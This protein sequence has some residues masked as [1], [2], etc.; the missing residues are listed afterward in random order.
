[1]QQVGP[2]PATVP[3]SPSFRMSRY[4][5]RPQCTHMMMNRVHGQ[6]L[7]CG[8]CGSPSDLGWLYQCEQDDRIPQN[9]SLPDIDATPVIPDSSDYF[10]AKARVAEHLHMSSSVI[11]GIRNGDYDVDQIDRLIAQKEKLISVITEKESLSATAPPNSVRNSFTAQNVISSIGSTYQAPHQNCRV[12][13]SLP[14]SATSTPPVPREDNIATPTKQDSV[15]GKRSQNKCCFQVCHSC[16]PYFGDRAY[17]NFETV[18]RN[19][20]HFLNELKGLPI[21]DANI[22]RNIGLRQPLP[23][24]LRSFQSQQS[25]DI[26][27]HD[28]TDDASTQISVD[29][30]PTNTNIEDESPLD[31]AELFPC[32]G[33]LQCPVWS[34]KSGCAYD[35]GFDDGKRAENHGFLSRITPEN[36]MS[37]FTGSVHGTPCE[38]SS[39]ASSISLPT[40]TRSPLAPL[41]ANSVCG[42]LNGE[43]QKIGLRSSSSSSLGSEIEVEGGV[44]LTEE[45]VEA[46]IPDIVTDE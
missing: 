44:A 33:P 39:T 36:S 34:R 22:A 37:L 27:V 45:A 24:I 26:T 46:R 14:A 35:A 41:K 13:A 5:R 28:S 21:M 18:L 7:I 43:N 25:M 38:A 15:L 32:P 29:W 2:A 20:P 42:E 8:M 3:P 11:Q 4:A 31:S 40:P 9:E 19:E 6:D 1:M 17:E 12:S 16:R 23:H 10:D 30:T